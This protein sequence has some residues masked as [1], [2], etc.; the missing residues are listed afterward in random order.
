M[1]NYLRNTTFFILLYLTFGWAD[2]V[3]QAF[4]NVSKKANPSVVSIVGT[5]SSQGS[6][7]FQDNY[8]NDPFYEYFPEFYDFLD[9][10]EMP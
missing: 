2:S 1:S 5:Q 6:S 4:I 7:G 8:N 9:E 3:S 10:F